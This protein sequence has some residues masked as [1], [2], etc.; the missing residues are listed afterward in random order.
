MIEPGL[1]GA[2]NTVMFKRRALGLPA[3][4]ST[5]QRIITDVGIEVEVI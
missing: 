2:P 5:I 1:G 4:V 3:R